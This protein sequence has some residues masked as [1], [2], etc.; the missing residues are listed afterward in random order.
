MVSKWVFAMGTLAFVL[1]ACSTQP[2]TAGSATPAND[3]GG[4][5]G[6]GT[7]DGSFGEPGDP[8][9]V[10][11]TIKVAQLDTLRFAPSRIE[12]KVGETVRFV[13]S[14]RGSID[15]EF[16]IGDIAFQQQHEIEM[17][18]GDGGMMANDPNAV[19]LAPGQSIDVFWKFTAPGMYLYGCHFPGHYAAGMLGEI[20]V[21]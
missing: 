9:M 8:A 4:M 18:G 13:V 21:T 6:Q 10:G 3:T 2:G 19:K 16:V 12:L 7:M 17:R 15:H 11:R 5:A 14:N 20:D 1:S